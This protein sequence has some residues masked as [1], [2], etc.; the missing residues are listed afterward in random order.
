MVG[1]VTEEPSSASYAYYFTGRVFPERASVSLVLSE[2]VGI[3]IPSLSWAGTVSLSIAVSQASIVFKGGPEVGDI[4][5][6]KNV[7]QTFAQGLVDVLGYQWGR[8]YDVE[9]TALVDANGTHHVFGVDV[10][11]IESNQHDRPVEV[12]SVLALAFAN[13]WLRRA[14]GDLREAIR[15]PDDT[16]FHC[17]RA[18]ES[19]RQ[20]FQVGPDVA[21]AWVA[22]RSALNLREETLKMLREFGTPQRHGEARAMSDAERGRDMTL[23]WKV[24]DRFVAFLDGSQADL[25]VATFPDM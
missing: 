9:V 7:A 6:L 5:T 15:E 17:M 12:Q 21:D 1:S 14:L 20:H 23:A 16:G 10:P 2:P 18:V 8:G 19:V 22:M 25:T 13:P 24:V 11:V 4:L 3:E